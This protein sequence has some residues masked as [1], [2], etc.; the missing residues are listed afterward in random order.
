[1]LD[2][3]VILAYFILNPA[4]KRRRVM[5]E[6]EKLSATSTAIANIPERK[7][8]LEVVVPNLS[9]ISTDEEKAQPV[10]VAL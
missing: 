7:P 9:M 4:A 5:E 10:Q 2:G 1:V 3:F 8:S 6:L